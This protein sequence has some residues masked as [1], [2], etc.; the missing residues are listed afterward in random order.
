MSANTTYE[1]LKAKYGKP[2]TS[3]ATVVV[4]KAISKAEQFSMALDELL[5][6]VSKTKV[7]K[8]ANSGKCMHVVMSVKDFSQD[9]ITKA[10]H[11][12]NLKL[13]S[14]PAGSPSRSRV[15]ESYIL[16]AATFGIQAGSW[17][18]VTPSGVEF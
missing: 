1:I 8:S 13:S 10:C 9:D 17:V 3:K 12:F 18:L 14:L 16:P 6:K 15:S 4:T 5:A 2:D 11:E 7:Q